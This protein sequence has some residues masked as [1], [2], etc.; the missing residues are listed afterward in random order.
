MNYADL[1]GCYPPRPKAEAD[2]TLRDLHISLYPTQPHS[3]ILINF[4]QPAICKFS[5][6]PNLNE[7]NQYPV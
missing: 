7:H 2:N 1:E 4:P 3:L 5:L 6:S